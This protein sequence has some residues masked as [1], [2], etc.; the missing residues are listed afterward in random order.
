[1]SHFE[2]LSNY[3]RFKTIEVKVGPIAIGGKN[4]IHIQSMTTANTMNTSA[5]VD[6]SIRMIDAGCK[7]VRIT[8]PS[9]KDAENLANIK[10][11]LRLKG[12]KTPLVADI[13]YTPNAAEIAAK[14]VEKV[15][16][17]PGNYA[18]KKK[19][20]EI[21]YTDES[22][23]NELLRIEE[24]FTP[25]VQ[26][27]KQNN[28]SMR[29]GTNH[30]SLSDRILSRYGD[31]P[32]GMVESALEFIRICRKH[33]YHNIVISMKASNTRVMVYAYRLLV[34]EMIKEGMK[35]P[36]HLGVTEAGEG[37]D[38][39][40][41]SAVGIGTLL[42][43]GIGD[44]IRV[45]LTEAPEHEM[46]VAQKI[47]DHF[48]NI[49]NHK[50]IAETKQHQIDYFQYEKRKTFQVE[51]IGNK[52]VPIVISD[53]SNRK[54]ITQASFFS[55]G[56]RYSVP[57]DKWHISE[58]ASDFIYIGENEINFEIPGTLRIISNYSSWTKHKKGFPIFN[59][60]EF[61]KIKDFSET[62]NFLKIYDHEITPSSIDI[63]KNN[64][65]LVIFLE[66]EN[67]NCIAAMRKF[68]F[69]LMEEKI[70][71]PIII[72]RKY[73]FNDDEQLQIS[74]SI[75][76][77]SLLIDG[78]GD[79]ICISSN[80]CSNKML[81][82]ISFGILQA[83]RTR[84]SKTEYISCPSCGRTLFDLQ[85]TTAKIRKVTDHLKGVKIGIMG[86]I[87]NG[88]GEM[89][90]ADYGYVGTG[91][92]KITLYKEK[93][94]VKKN[95]PESE[96]VDALIDLIKENGDWVDKSN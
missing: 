81:N 29:I 79:G 28:T 1:M 88:P 77:G 67:I 2:N 92:G 59:L 68:F 15:R 46:P 49:H 53:L 22:Y 11:E 34:N 30:G 50:K 52:N 23:N 41:K 76:I 39:R 82:S 32:K 45:S 5:T 55:L 47:L 40:I 25:L 19:F 93:T 84:I 21:D 69:E 78:L 37:E 6:E 43:E 58:M 9:K 54:K 74:A 13:H 44:T 38:G 17:N 87:V 48:K 14:I 66:S 89:A 71:N 36:L 56:Y 94:V 95:V 85:E 31:T 26:I 75:D 63:L 10:N 24:K 18:D 16:I 65:S 96:A 60:K 64:K 61:E 33:D 3:T 51:N 12:Y 57:L 86:C 83:S 73:E 8:A 42:S 27:C 35:Y 20:E 4:P 72:S 80:N 7:L 91:P 70:E 90:D 62:L